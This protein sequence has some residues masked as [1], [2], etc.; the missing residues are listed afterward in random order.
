MPFITFEVYEFALVSLDGKAADL[1]DTGRLR[2]TDKRGE[3]IKVE[4]KRC[5][6]EEWKE[7]TAEDLDIF[8][9]VAKRYA[10]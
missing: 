9:R 8:I 4:V 1:S 5:K 2:I 3:P 7:P 6:E 10:E